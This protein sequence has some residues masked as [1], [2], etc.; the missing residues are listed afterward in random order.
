MK[1]NKT[2][3]ELHSDI[4]RDVYIPAVEARERAVGET[5]WTEKE[6][7]VKDDIQDV[8]VE[9]TEQEREGILYVLKLFTKYEDVVGDEFWGGRFKQIFGRHEM[10]QMAA[11]FAQTELCVHLPFYHRIN[12]LLN[13]GDDFYTSYKQDEILAARMRHLEEMINHENDLVSLGAFTFVEGVILFTS[14]AYLKHFQENGKNKIKNI[15]SGINYSSREEQLHAEAAAWSF[16]TLLEQRKEAKLITGDE[17]SDVYSM[18]LKSADEA[19]NHE[20]G[21]IDKILAKGDIDGFAKAD[22]IQF[23]QHRVAK[24]LKDLGIPQDKYSID[25]GPIADWYYNSVEGY[26]QIDFFTSKGRE[27]N[28]KWNVN[29]FKWEN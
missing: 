16:K 8:L 4:Y 20:V 10:R 28:R 17:I 26:T 6:V 18:V 13:V 22:A 12:E 2:H 15:V 5:Y 3:I 9:C 14:F 19:Y 25:G 23:M 21:I 29:Y 7:R 1:I 24:N 27:Y 11:A